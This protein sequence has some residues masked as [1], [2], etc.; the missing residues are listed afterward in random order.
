MS[1]DL[2][3]T[4]VPGPHY[5]G[6]VRDV[7]H[8][9]WDMIIAHP[10]CT[11]L[12]T[13][14]AKHFAVKRADGRQQEAIDFFM[15][16]AKHSCSKMM[17]ENPVGIMSTVWK[18]P[19]QIVQ[20]YYYGDPYTKTTCL[21]LKGLPRLNAT[22][23]VDKGARTVTKGGKSMP[24]WYNIPPTNPDRAKIRSKTFPGFAQAMADQWG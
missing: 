5:R 15:L 16:F 8:S 12:A 7:L 17:I 10:P 22:N 18:K 4:D 9:T 1:C 21:W 19:T 11:H 20:P 14:G 6:D 2:L 13:S 3:D 23:I 24:T